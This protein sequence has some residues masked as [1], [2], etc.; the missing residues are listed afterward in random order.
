MK[1][2]KISKNWITEH[3]RDFFFKQSKIQGYR[4]RAA[5]KLIEMNDKFKFI[6]NNTRLL[7]L[8]SH[9][10]GWSQVA[11]KLITKGKILATD[12]KYM[13]KLEKVSFMMGD[14]NDKEFYKEIYKYFNK[15]IDVIISDMAANTTGNKN[16]D[17]Y[18]TGELCL[19]A[20]ELAKQILKKDCVFLSKV[21]MGAVFEE[22]HEKAKRCFNKVIKYKPLAC[23]SGSKEI[24]F[25]C[26]GKIN[27]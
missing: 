17:A 24:Y 18:R 21:F 5:Y 12:I 15:K 19:N 25:F 9:P 27:I 23:K 14:M 16:L 11:A 7:D 2:S 6:K 1:K 10:G 3:K 13:K 22:V 4:S 26:K 8:G 20:M